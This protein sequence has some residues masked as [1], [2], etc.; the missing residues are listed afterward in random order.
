MFFG[1][2]INALG[3]ITPFLKEELDLTYTVSSLHFTALAAGFLIA[4][5]LGQWVVARI[6]RRLALWVGLAGLSLGV[7]LLLIGTTPVMTIGAVLVIGILGGQIFVI[8][9]SAF[10]DQYG[11]QK[12]IPLAESNMFG[13]VIGILAPLMIGW[14]VLWLGDWRFAL[15]A[16]AL[17]PL[18]MFA[19]FRTV[20]VPAPAIRQA[21]AAQ[22]PLP[23]TFWLYW[24]AIFLAVSV[25]FCMISWSAD[26]LRNGYSMAQADAAQAV[27]LFLGGMIVGRLAGSVFVQRYHARLLVL[28]SLIIAALGFALF[29]LGGL[30]W[31]SLIGLF[32]TG[33]GVASLYPLILSLALGT[34]ADAVQASARASLASGAAILILPLALGRIADAIGIQQAYGI[35]ALLIFGA[36]A[37][38]YWAGRKS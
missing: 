34:T 11:D 6:G 9:P 5:V 27:S 28:L 15:G 31:L 26:Y 18:V 22:P 2:Y 3:P 20:E 35:V 8:I 4:G 16:V 17:V 12:A 38:V 29:W 33:V 37:I 7:A 21:D 13:S 36:L 30:M 23:L 25:E 24:F 10:A 1:F 19:I 14:S 32:L